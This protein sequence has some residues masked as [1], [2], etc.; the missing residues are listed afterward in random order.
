MVGWLVGGWWVGGLVDGWS[1][2][3]WR[4]QEIGGW[5]GVVGGWLVGWWV[6]GR[7]VGWC[8][9]TAGD[10]WVQQMRVAAEYKSVKCL[11]TLTKL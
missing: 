9:E 4:Q 11:L 5:V 3:V 1:V 8:V 7:L 10:L 2:G 6:G